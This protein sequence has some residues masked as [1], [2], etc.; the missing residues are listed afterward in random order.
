M[1]DES[2]VGTLVEETTEWRRE[3]GEVRSKVTVNVFGML[4]AERTSRGVSA[5]R[6]R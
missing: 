3:Y 2:G 6:P 4:L 1:G 5:G